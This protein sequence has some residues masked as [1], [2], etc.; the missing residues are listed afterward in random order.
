MAVVECIFSALA[1]RP[2]ER[3]VVEAVC[4]NGI[5]FFAGSCVQLIQAI[6][7]TAVFDI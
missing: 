1:D 2:E 7:H 3:F 6:I 4:G 5:G